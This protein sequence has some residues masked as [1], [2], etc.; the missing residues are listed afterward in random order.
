[1][2]HSRIIRSTNPPAAS[3][4]PTPTT[5]LVP[6]VF[7]GRIARAGHGTASRS[8]RPLDGP[9]GCFAP[10]AGITV[11]SGPA[12]FAHG[13]AARRVGV[14]APPSRGAVL[15]CIRQFRSGPAVPRTGDETRRA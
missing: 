2:I 7:V 5:P 14:L 13:A 9:S 1:M 6:H 11:V 4:G 15:P 8:A 12:G 3:A 10:H